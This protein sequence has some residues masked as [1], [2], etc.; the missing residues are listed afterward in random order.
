MGTKTGY[1]T[2][3]KGKKKRARKKI[4][5]DPPCAKNKKLPNYI[6]LAENYVLISVGNLFFSHFYANSLLTGKKTVQK[7]RF[8]PKNW[9]T[10]KG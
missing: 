4:E 9:L 3:G 1:K 2:K 5:V 7:R 8:F 6:Q 10:A